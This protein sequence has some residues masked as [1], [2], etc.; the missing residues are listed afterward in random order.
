MYGTFNR[1]YRVNAFKIYDYGV[2]MT[3]GTIVVFLNQGRFGYLVRVN[4]PLEL[5]NHKL[6]FSSRHSHLQEVTTNDTPLNSRQPCIVLSISNSL[7]CFLYLMFVSF[8]VSFFVFCQFWQGSYKNQ[9][10]F[11]GKDSTA[12]FFKMTKNE[13]QNMG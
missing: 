9:L 13:N 4:V 7:T 12:D 8:H 3:E 1:V 2:Y 6:K 5:Q 10:P 11:S